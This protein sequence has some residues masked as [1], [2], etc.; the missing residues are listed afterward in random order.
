MDKKTRIKFNILAIFCIIIFAFSL[1]PKTLQN[2]TYYTISIGEYITEN[3]IV[4]K[5]PFSW[6]DIKYTYPHWLYDVCIYRI[7]S[8][9]GMDGIYIS[10]VV[11][12]CLLGVLLYI[13]SS[14][15]NKKP[16]FAFIIT[17]KYDTS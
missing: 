1:T 5:D 7:Y 10:T 16:L 17:T 13:T 15:V 11:L 12:S 6:H 9:F 8:A 2:D 3:G 4:E 14:K